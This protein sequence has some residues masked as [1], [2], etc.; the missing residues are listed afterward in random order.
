MPDRDTTRQDLA[1]DAAR[2][3][4]LEERVI[5]LAPS[6]GWYR[7]QYQLPKSKTTVEVN[8]T[9]VDSGSITTPRSKLMTDKYPVDRDKTPWKVRL[10]KIESRQK[11]LV[12]KYSVPFP[13]RGVRIV[14]KSAARDFFRDLDDVKRDLQAAANEFVADLDGIIQQMKDKTP[15]EV[16]KAVEAKIPKQR[17][18]MRA[19]F[20]ID[21]VPVEIAGTTPSVLTEGD[22]REHYDMVQEAC[23]RKVDEAIE[24]MIEAPR[25]Q[26]AEA[27]AGLKDVIDRNGRVSTKSFK[28][29]TEAIAKLRSFSFVASDALMEEI[30]RL[31]RRLGNTVP[32]TLDQ[33]TAASSGF[34]AA[35]DAVLAE[36]SDASKQAADMERFGREYRGIQ[37]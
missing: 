1:H 23:R 37:L 36:V 22:L 30:N 15:E 11:G 16:Y 34:T 18:Q 8:D 21:V 12:E 7:G 14:P 9:E 6:F 26:L 5:L 27:L 10:Q 35:L 17:D 24:A 31:E 4:A 28:P 32:N 3:R 29:V 20:Y 13:I 2:R 33:R 25:A 19:K